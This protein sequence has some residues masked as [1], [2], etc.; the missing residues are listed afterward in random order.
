M[1]LMREK[2]DVC[3]RK[4]DFPAAGGGKRE[5]ISIG[6][7]SCFMGISLITM[8]FPMNANPGKFCYGKKIGKN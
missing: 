8:D 3:L 2:T 1:L 6:K 5:T 4:P 7:T